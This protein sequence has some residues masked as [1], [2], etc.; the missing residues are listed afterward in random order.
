MVSLVRRVLILSLLL[1][2]FGVVHAQSG[3]GVMEEED[4]PCLKHMRKVLSPEGLGDLVQ[5][6]L[7]S[8]K[9]LNELGDY[10]SCN[11]DGLEYSLL[12]LE[13]MPIGFTVL[14]LGLCVPQE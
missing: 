2:V 9:G 8:A 11:A 10:E 5:V 13:L 1:L 12:A 4:T 14:R 3:Q 7:N 6:A